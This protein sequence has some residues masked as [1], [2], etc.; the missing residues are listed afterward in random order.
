M[1]KNRSQRELAGLARAVSDAMVKLLNLQ[2]LRTQP[3][4]DFTQVELLLPTY[5]Q[6]Q[7]TPLQLSLQPFGLSSNRT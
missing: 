4:N 2:L 1:T 6:D 5:C 7:F 3:G